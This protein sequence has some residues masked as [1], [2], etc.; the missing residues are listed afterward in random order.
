[1]KIAKSGHVAPWIGYALGFVGVVAALL[2]LMNPQAVIDAIWV[3]LE[4]VRPMP[5]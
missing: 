1:M 3:L 5:I 4:I 2:F